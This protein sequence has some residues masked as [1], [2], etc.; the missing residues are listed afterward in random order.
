[1]KKSTHEAAGIELV[2][3]SKL[4]DLD[5]SDNVAFLHDY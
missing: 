5:F 1:M 3:E 4:G 2:D